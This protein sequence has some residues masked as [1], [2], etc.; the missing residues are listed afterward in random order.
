[1]LLRRGQPSIYQRLR[2]LEVAA[3]L[4]RREDHPNLVAIKSDPT[5]IM[6]L[7]GMP[8]DIWQQQLLQSQADR[9]LLLCSRQVGKSTVAA[10]LALRVALIR[11]HSPILVL[12]PTER[13]SGELLRK[14]AYLFNQLNRP[15]Q[16]VRESALQVEFA[17]RSRILSLPGNEATVR[18]FSDIAMLIIDEASRVADSLY[19]AVR[20]MLAV[21]HGSLVALSTPFGKR[22]WFHDEWDGPGDWERIK[23][24]ADQCPR[25][26]PQFL[27]EERRA[28][29]DRWYRQE[30]LCE[31]NDTI[32]AVFSYSDI[33][34]ALSDDVKPLFARTTP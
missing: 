1:M 5:L 25:I 31:F 16:V 28:L 23:I 27:A 30:Y 34:A 18:G 20:P 2:R 3:G 22:G 24:T 4:L 9:F 17:N 33:Q 6:T 19:Y 10:A 32:D 21:S 14:I 29:G 11:P 26:T 13:Q 7:A 15:V 12:A 8:P